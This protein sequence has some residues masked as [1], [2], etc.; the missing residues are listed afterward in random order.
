[1]VTAYKSAWDAAAR[2]W[3]FKGSATNPEDIAHARENTPSM[4]TLEWLDIQHPDD[5]DSNAEKSVLSDITR[6]EKNARQ[7]AE[8]ERLERA[9]PKSAPKPKSSPYDD[10]DN[11]PSR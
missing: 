5:A 6:D 7:K 1:M 3:P 4:V 8:L 11:G 10:W 9:R 2:L